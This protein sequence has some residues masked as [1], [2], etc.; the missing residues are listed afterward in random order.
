MTA[1]VGPIRA[2]LTD[3]NSVEVCHLLDETTDDLDFRDRVIKMCLGG[4]YFILIILIMHK[5]FAWCST[6]THSHSCD[7]G[8]TLQ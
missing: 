4:A 7:M 1:E 6:H 5:P 3:S 8:Y 2:T